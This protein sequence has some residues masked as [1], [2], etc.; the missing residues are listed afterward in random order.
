VTPSA[1]QGSSP[2]D[3]AQ[4]FRLLIESL[5]DYAVFTMDLSGVITTWNS[6]VRQ[7]LG[8]EADEFVGLPFS[9]IFTPED[10]A[11]GR[12]SQELERALTTG[13]SD[14]RRTH[15][16]KDG[17]RFPADGVVTLIRDAHGAAHAFSKVMHDVTVQQRAS[18]ALRQ[19]EEKYR[20][21]VESVRDYAIFL[22]DVSGRVASWTP[23]AERLLGYTG[24]EI[25]GEHFRRF[26]GADDQRRGLPEQ[27]LSGALAMGRVESEGWRMRKDGSR[28][29][30]DEIISPIRDEAGELRGF[31]K[32]VR[33][34][35]ERQRAALEREQLYTQAQEANRLKDEFL[36]TVSHELRTPLNA[37]LGWVHLL[38]TEGLELDEPRRRRAIRTI[39]RN[40]MVQVQLVDDLLDVSRIISGKMR[41]QIG[42]VVLADVLSAAVDAIRPAATAKN[43]EVR[44][45]VE[46]ADALITADPDRLQQIVWNLLSNAI[47]FTSSGG[48]IDLRAHQSERGTEIVVSDT[49]IGIA[50]EVLPFV[51]D[52]FRQADS[53]TTRAQGGVGLGLA[54]VRHLVELHG[55]SV[56]ARSEGEGKGATFM[57]RLP[58]SAVAPPA[59]E[60]GQPVRTVERRDAATPLLTNVR[61]VV[62]DDDLDTREV[63]TTVLRRSQAEVIA[64]DSAAEALA[65]IDSRTPDVIIADIGMPGVDGYALIQKVRVRPADRG[66]RTPAIAVT[67]YAREQDRERALAAGYQLHV[68]KPFDPNDV[69]KAV[70]QL[71]VRPAADQ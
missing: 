19:S 10:V 32:V 46:P 36:G 47:K 42:P 16:R 66:G 34:L 58:A 30:G 51:F 1:N 31:A 29:W 15:L 43:M 52:R 21:L 11:L 5:S 4:Q 55:G 64:V 60:T 54:I 48:V 44:M 17:S 12:P 22:L 38:E 13:R 7:V 8:Y 3:P 57:V 40:A 9:A 61:V 41:L 56:E 2:P 6:G 71:V 14:D 49:G 67:A 50:P 20:L 37:I 33:D 63:L 24:D 68:S 39:A 35:T 26:F 45:A 65:Q 70:A 18:E 53:S 69:V 25:I 28:F 62:V 23:A 59:E 27:E